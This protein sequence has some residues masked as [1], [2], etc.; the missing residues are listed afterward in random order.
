MHKPSHPCLAWC[1]ESALAL[2]SGSV[3]S[4]LALSGVRF[5]VAMSPMVQLTGSVATVSCLKPAAMQR[6]VSSGMQKV[7]NGQGRVLTK[8]GG[9]QN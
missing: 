9:D 3:G 8:Q 2:C 6:G 5:T 7:S 4:V 1:P